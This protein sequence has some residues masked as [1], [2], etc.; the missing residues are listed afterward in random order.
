LFVV[1]LTAITGS[2]ISISCDGTVIY[3][4]R[5][6][7]KMAK[8]NLF[9]L[10]P[11]IAVILSKMAE[12]RH[13]TEATVLEMLIRKEAIETGIIGADHP[14][15]AFWYLVNVIKGWAIPAH[16]DFTRRVFEHIDSTPD[17]LRLWEQAVT[18]LPGQRADKR[19]QWVNQRLGRFCKRLI[20]WE[21]A[22]EVQ[23]GKGSVALIQSFTRLKP[24]ATAF[25]STSPPG[26][27]GLDDRHRDENGQR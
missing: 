12:E 16:E 15:A 27:T 1:P 24:S 20:G 5:R 8:E 11:D 2:V 26:A 13:F 3:T 9:R 25:D 17:A 21:S 23:L 6:E 19:K 22:E 10:S 4:V 18:P 7:Q 14:E